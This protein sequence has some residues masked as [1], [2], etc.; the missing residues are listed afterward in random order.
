MEHKNPPNKMP[1]PLMIS[2]D[3]VLFFRESLAEIKADVKEIKKT[4]HEQDKELSLLKWKLMAM[5]MLGGGGAHYGLKFFG[6]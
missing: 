6:L 1:E 5:S 3:T 4:Q 2:A